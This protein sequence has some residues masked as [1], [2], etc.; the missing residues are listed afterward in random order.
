MHADDSYIGPGPTEHPETPNPT[1]RPRFT[2]CRSWL[3]SI[4]LN[5]PL[6]LQRAIVLLR[7]MAKH[8]RLDEHPRAPP[9]GVPRT[10]QVRD[11]LPIKIYS[12]SVLRL[13]LHP[14][15]FFFQTPLKWA[16]RALAKPITHAYSP[17]TQ[18]ARFRTGQ[19]Y[20]QH[21]DRLTN[22]TSTQGHWFTTLLSNL[23][24]YIVAPAVYVREVTMILYLTDTLE[25]A[26]PITAGP[27]GALRL[28]FGP[29][30]CHD[31]IH[32]VIRIDPLP[33]RLVLFRSDLM[34]SVEVHNGSSDR[35]ALTLWLG[36][37]TWPF[38]GRLD[39]RGRGDIT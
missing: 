10:L 36:G 31:S 19:Y 26:S 1:L 27:G 12:H 22:T 2:P 35:I 33:G 39:N 30:Y 4:A 16:S 14:P 38:G 25:Q 18:L 3:H 17:L 20:R 32:E 24:L 7:S 21:R 11:S 28:D 6:G 23:H 37:R 8:L 5:K 13:H 34:H 29:E 9:L 15:F